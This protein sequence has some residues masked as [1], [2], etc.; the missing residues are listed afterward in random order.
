MQRILDHACNALRPEN[1]PTANVTSAGSGFE[2]DTHGM[3][4]LIREK[5]TTHYLSTW[6]ALNT[7]GTQVQLW[8]RENESGAVLNSMVLP[9]HSMRCFK[10]LTLFICQVFFIDSTG[11]LCHAASGLAVDIVGESYKSALACSSEDELAG[12]VQ[13]M[14]PFC[15]DV[16]PFPVAQTRGHAPC[17]NS[18]SSTRR[19]A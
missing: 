13:M 8:R 6:C 16:D 14:C 18:P 3:Y 12:S 19:Y 15:V 5:G 9:Y 4:F 7:E 10:K 2:R 17:Q 11:A 1:V